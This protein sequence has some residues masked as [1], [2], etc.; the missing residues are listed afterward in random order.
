MEISSQF[1]K[2]EGRA[3]IQI[4][5]WILLIGILLS[6]LIYGLSFFVARPTVETVTTQA[7]QLNPETNA[8]Q[9][10]IIRRRKSRRFQS[11]SISNLSAIR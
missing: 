8:N 10:T 3:F 2:I 4:V 5:W 9:E 1:Q 11:N 7:P 6:F